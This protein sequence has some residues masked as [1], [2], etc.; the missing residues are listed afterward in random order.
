MVDEILS[1]HE[2]LGEITKIDSSQQ[3]V[4]YAR[5]LFG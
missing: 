1:K 4:E 2:R 3:L 5:L